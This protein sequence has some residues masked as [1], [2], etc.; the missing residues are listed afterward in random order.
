MW[1]WSYDSN[2]VS[3]SKQISN[4]AH[5]N[6]EHPIIITDESEDHQTS[7]LSFSLPELKDVWSERILLSYDQTKIEV[8]NISLT[9]EYNENRQNLFIKRTENSKGVAE[10]VVAPLDDLAISD[11]EGDF[12]S[13]KLSS[14]K[15]GFTG[16]ITIAYDL[17]DKNGA[18]L[19]SGVIEHRLEITSSIPGEYSL[20]NNYPNPFNPATTI[21]FDI[22]VSGK[23]ILKIF[24]LLGEEITTLVEEEFEAGRHSVK[25]EGLNNAKELVS[26]GVYF[27]S[28]KAGSFSAVK[29]MILIR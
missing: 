7:L 9:P 22:P 20:K 4:F 26:S 6:S 1:N 29:K 21:E 24:N 16:S 14:D 12:F 25:W 3:L 5:I 2:N 10:I 11:W 17:R 19:S 13:V 23:V 15:N 18:I 8:R 28:I 27:Y